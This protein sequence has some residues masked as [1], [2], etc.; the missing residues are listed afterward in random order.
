M[1]I[2]AGAAR[3]RSLQAP[4][5]RDT[6]PTSDRAREGLFSTL[7]TLLDLAQRRE[8]DVLGAAQSGRRSRL[9]LL[10][11]LRDGDLIV[12]ARTEATAFVDGDPELDAHPVL[13]DAIAAMLDE[14]RAEYLEKA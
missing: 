2:V 13:R 9:R 10:E 3:G 7:G 4:P 1:R 5:G 6:R 8:G 11:L 14:E 12:A